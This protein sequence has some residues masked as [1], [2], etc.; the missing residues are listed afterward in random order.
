MT[1]HVVFMNRGLTW[2]TER[3]LHDFSE[4]KCS[5]LT[6]KLVQIIVNCMVNLLHLNK[7]LIKNFYVVNVANVCVI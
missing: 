6:L 2:A 7:M 4:K 1:M 5:F 3:K